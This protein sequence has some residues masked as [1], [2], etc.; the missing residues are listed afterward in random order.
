[1]KKI[2]LR[3]TVPGLTI[4]FTY[5]LF[6]E[7][8]VVHKSIRLRITCETNVRVLG[9]ANSSKLAR[10]E[11]YFFADEKTLTKLLSRVSFG[12]CILYDLHFDIRDKVGLKY[13][14]R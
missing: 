7:E 1:M 12:K 4:I 11:V 13:N 3:E 2:L 10:K 9:F 6:S 14:F 5:E 8:I